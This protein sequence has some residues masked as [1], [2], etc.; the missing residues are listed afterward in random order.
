MKDLTELS[1]RTK[2]NLSKVFQHQIE[3][4]EELKMTQEAIYRIRTTQAP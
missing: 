2:R 1:E 3:K 4:L